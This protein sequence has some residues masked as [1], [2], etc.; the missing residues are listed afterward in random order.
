MNAVAFGELTAVGPS[1]AAKRTI[2]ELST[3][4]RRIA[5]VP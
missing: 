4:W 3:P 2:P 1:S 5:A